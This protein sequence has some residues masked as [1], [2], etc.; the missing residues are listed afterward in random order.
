MRRLSLSARLRSNNALLLVF[1][2]LAVVGIYF[3]YSSPSSEEMATRTIAPSWRPTYVDAVVMIAASSMAA[4]KMVDM[5]IAS[6]RRYGNWRGPIY[7]LTDRPDCFDASAKEFGVTVVSI[8]E[9][10]NILE[11]KALKMSLFEY[12]PEDL[13]GVLYVDVD[14]VVTRDLDDFLFDS[15]QKIN[16]MRGKFDMAMFL[17]AAGHYVGFC[18]GCEKWHSGVIIMRRG[19]GSGC[20]AK[21]KEI[22]LSGKYG[23]DQQSIDEAERQGSCPKMVTLYKKHLLFAKD[24]LGV[25]LTPGRTFLHMTGAGR[26]GLQDYFYRNFAIPYFKK[27]LSKLDGPRFEGQKT[28]SEAVSTSVASSVPPPPKESTLTSTSA[29]TS[30]NS[31]NNNN[32][33]DN[34][35]GG[36]TKLRKSG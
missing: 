16:R 32:K 7:V 6:V 18:S 4:D 12:L 27:S 30:R 20:L 5:S 14:I 26:L 31:D 34:K 17:D 29:S 8:P 28:C 2:L 11:I 24:Y 19:Q 10:L 3:I 36:S 25:A 1:W 21:W 35:S 9:M 23:T 33:N 22:L 15:E 13:K